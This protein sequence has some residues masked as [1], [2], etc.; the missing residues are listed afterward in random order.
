MAQDIGQDLR[1]S[2]VLTSDHVTYPWYQE[3]TNQ[4]L[5]TKWVVNRTLPYLT[6]LV[7]PQEYSADVLAQDSA[8]LP[9]EGPT[10]EDLNILHLAHLVLVIT[11]DVVSS[12]YYL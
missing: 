9:G 8:T 11:P 12:E 7:C 3:C 1:G 5:N 10:K 4:I 6:V 2:Q